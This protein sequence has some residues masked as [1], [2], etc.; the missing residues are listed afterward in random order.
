[1][2]VLVTIIYAVACVAPKLSPRRDKLACGMSST[3]ELHSSS[4][5]DS[6]SLSESSLSA[7][8]NLRLKKIQRA[9]DKG[10]HTRH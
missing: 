6:S 8:K 1:M 2:R 5:S 9:E 4:Q 3:F 10:T 7:S